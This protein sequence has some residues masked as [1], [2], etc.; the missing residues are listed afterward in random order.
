MSRAYPKTPLVGVGGIVVNNERVLLVRRGNEP[1]RGDWSIPGGML[2]LG[3][4]LQECAE[5]EILEECDIEAHAEEVVGVTDLIQFD[6]E[7]AIEYHYVLIDLLAE[8]IDGIPKPS[9]DVFAAEWVPFDELSSLKMPDRLRA[10]LVE[11]CQPNKAERE[12][13]D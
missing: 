7:G 10:L 2:N 11:H 4:T 5:R 8:Y 9:S 3:E 12:R 6:D 13:E 1:G